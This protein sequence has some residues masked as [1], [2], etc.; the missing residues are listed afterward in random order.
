MGIDDRSAFTIFPTLTHNLSR[1]FYAFLV[2]QLADLHD[3]LSL[4]DIVLFRMLAK[5]KVR[6]K[7]ENE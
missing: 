1:L 6:G 3:L 5:R 2:R 4:D 7:T